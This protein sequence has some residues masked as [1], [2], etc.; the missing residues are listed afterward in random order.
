LDRTVFGRPR[1]VGE[2]R[3]ADIEHEQCH[4][5]RSPGLELARGIIAY[6]PELRDGGVNTSDSG[7][8]DFVRGVQ[9]V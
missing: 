5:P 2:E 4:A 7:R 8:R 6:E 1:D 9:D 3:I